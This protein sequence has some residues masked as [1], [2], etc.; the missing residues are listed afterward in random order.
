M[1]QFFSQRQQAEKRAR[2]K[3]RNANAFSL[4]DISRTRL[5]GEYDIAPSVYGRILHKVQP[6]L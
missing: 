1:K 3:R 5:N 6:L 4:L 2:Y